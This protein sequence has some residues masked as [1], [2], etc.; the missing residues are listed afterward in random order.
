MFLPAASGKRTGA[1]GTVAA[2]WLYDAQARPRATPGPGQVPPIPA[3][4]R[5]LRRRRTVA[6]TADARIGHVQFLIL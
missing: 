3:P 2:R 6:A 4:G 1:P 5:I